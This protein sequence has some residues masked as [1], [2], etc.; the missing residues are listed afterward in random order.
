MATFTA[1]GQPIPS[2]TVYV[3]AGVLS[4]VNCRA[5]FMRCQVH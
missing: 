5:S 1:D 3:H 2:G 4:E